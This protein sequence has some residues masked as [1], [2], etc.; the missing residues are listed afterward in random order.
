MHTPRRDPHVKESTAPSPCLQ[1][2]ESRFSQ[3]TCSK[4]TPIKN[5]DGV[6][7]QCKMQDSRLF[8]TAV[9]ASSC[10]AWKW[11]AVRRSIVFLLSSHILSSFLH[12]RIPWH[13]LFSSPRNPPPLA[14]T[15]PACMSFHLH[16]HAYTRDDEQTP[17]RRKSGSAMVISIEMTE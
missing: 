10:L 17:L 16:A 8:P 2:T 12:V 11:P 15:L 1:H 9:L 6:E 7:A 13:A 4:R 5:T 14:S 3:L